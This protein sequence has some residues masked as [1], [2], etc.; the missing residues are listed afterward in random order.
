[1]ST[2][3]F[4]FSD[5]STQQLTLPTVDGIQSVPIV[6]GGV[7]QNVPFERFILADESSVFI[8]VLTAFISSGIL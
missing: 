6:R 5:N 7:S 2:L 8:F 1:M 3:D 4:T